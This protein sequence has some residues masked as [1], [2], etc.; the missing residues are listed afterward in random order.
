MSP[1][2]C[3]V[4]ASPLALLSNGKSYAC[5]NN[6]LFD[7]ARQGYTNLLLNQHKKSRLPGDTSEMVEART[8]FLNA[9]YYQAIVDGIIALLQPHMAQLDSNQAL[10]YTDIACGEGYYTCALEQSFTQSFPENRCVSTG[11]D[12]STP[13]IKAACRR[14]KNITWLVAN[15]TAL[16]I[17]TGSQQ[18]ASYLFCRVDYQEAARILAPGGMLVIAETGTEHLLELRKAIYK[19]LK[20]D[21]VASDT[22]QKSDSLELLD[23]LHVLKSLSVKSGE[24]LMNLLKMTPHYWRSSSEAR[25]S[26]A[27]LDALDLTLDIKLTLFRKSTGSQH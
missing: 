5:G 22:C 20:A 11:I 17:E 9:G 21:T 12:I 24:M 27:T 10:N 26:L 23:T 2:I 1:L 25:T 15:A 6:H 18:L 3:P 13:A 16:P 14:N 7:R 19:H 8:A 4:C